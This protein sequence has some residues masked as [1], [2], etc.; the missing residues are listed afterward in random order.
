LTFCNF[1][2]SEIPKLPFQCKYCGETFCTDHRLPENHNCSFDFKKE[3]LE[4]TTKETVRVKVPKYRSGKKNYLNGTTLLF[5]FII[6]MSILGYFFPDYLCITSRTMYQ[7]YFWT[8]LTSFFVLYA[9]T[10]HEFAYFIVLVVL[11]YK[12]LRSIEKEFG[13]FVVLKALIVTAILTGIINLGLDIA[14]QENIESMYPLYP[15]DLIFFVT[16]PIGLASGTL[17]GLITFYFM[18]HKFKKKFRIKDWEIKGIYMLLFLVI[19][20]TI[21]KIFSALIVASNSL[22]PY[23]EVEYSG[24]LFL[25]VQFDIWGF[26]GGIFASEIKRAA[27]SLFK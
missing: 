1:C 26:G 8:I 27:N 10:I 3:P 14:W 13:M 19:F 7:K 4:P 9:E 5:S 22:L 12:Y 18:K 20:S 23:H 25:W 24:I 21:S 2:G 17:L 6:M 15:N 16:P 11:S